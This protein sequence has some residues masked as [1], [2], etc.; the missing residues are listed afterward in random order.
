MFWLAL[1]AK[2][3]VTAAFVALAT[4]VAQ[5][6]G[7]LLGG[8]IATLPISAGPA[9][10]FI[11]LDRGSEFVAESAI[12]SLVTNAVTMFFALTYV[13][14]AQAR[15][16]LTSL[17]G[18]LGLWLVLAMSLRPLPWTLSGA[19]LLNI[20]ACIICLPPSRPFR[21]I[22]M[23]VAPRRW[24]DLPVRAVMVATLVAVVVG[25]SSHVG[26][27]LTGILAVFPI[28]LTSLIL[29][30]QPRIGGPATASLI[31][32]TI[33]GLVGFALALVVLNVAALTLGTSAALTLALAVSIA[34]NLILW[35]SRR[36]RLRV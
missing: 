23:P 2:M 1:A 19:A 11:A 15:S 22:R 29:I 21:R 17:V 36:Q 13:L 3:S 18:A 4:A 24:Y 34:W 8:L 14:L 32:H 35:L 5:R 6:G 30:F 31:A 27:A 12:A 26:P 9:Y 7:P 10:L 28:V 16:F 20:A 33:P 25:V